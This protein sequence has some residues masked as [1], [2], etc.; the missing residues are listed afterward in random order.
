MLESAYAEDRILV[1]ANVGDF[2]KLARSTDLHRGI[3]LVEQGDLLRDEQFELLERALL[4]LE[5]QSHDLINHVLRISPNKA[6][7]IEPVPK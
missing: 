4:Y 6:P 5:T 3:I 7:E 1:T 2:E